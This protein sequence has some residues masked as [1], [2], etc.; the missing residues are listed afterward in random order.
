MIIIMN[1]H[2]LDTTLVASALAVVFLGSA[3]SHIPGNQAPTPLQSS[4][5]ACKF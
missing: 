4:A 5:I 1:S 2:F 3:T